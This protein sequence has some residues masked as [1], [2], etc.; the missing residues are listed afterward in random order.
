MRLIWNS[1]VRI[2][3]FFVTAPAAPFLFCVA[4]WKMLAKFR[5]QTGENREFLYE[6]MAQS[7]LWIYNW[8]SFDLKQFWTQYFCLEKKILFKKIQIVCSPIGLGGLK[9]STKSPWTKNIGSIL[10]GGGT[11]LGKQSKHKQYDQSTVGN[12]IERASCRLAECVVFAKIYW[13]KPAPH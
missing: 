9:S 2:G 8:S 10:V 12:Y 11:P 5:Y 7:P 13:S 6:W 3:V 4:R 1:D